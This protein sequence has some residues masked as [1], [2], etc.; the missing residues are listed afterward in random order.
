MTLRGF[1]SSNGF[2]IG[3]VFVVLLAWVRSRSAHRVMPIDPSHPRWSEAVARARNTLNDMRRLFA[4]GFDVYVKYPVHTK[5]GTIEHVWGKLL[6]LSPESMKVTLET[7]LIM[8]LPPDT[9]PPFS[10]AVAEI[11]DWQVLQADNKVRGGYTTRL[12]IEVAREQGAR[13]PAH[14]AALEGRF[15]DGPN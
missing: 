6:E 10:I 15:I 1:L 14:I 11:E 13:L 8:P 5:S 4:D 3:I 2:L 12:Q 9:A 7:P